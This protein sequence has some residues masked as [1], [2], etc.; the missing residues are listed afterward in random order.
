MA[1]KKELLNMLHEAVGFEDHI[2]L[3]ELEKFAGRVE[4]E[5]LKQTLKELIRDTSRHVLELAKLIEKVER[6]GK[7]DF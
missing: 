5:K 1:A 3:I 4:D 7:D 6:S 2:V